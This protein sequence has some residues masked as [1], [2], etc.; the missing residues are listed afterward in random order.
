VLERAVQRAGELPRQ[1]SRPDA[2][3]GPGPVLEHHD[4]LAGDRIRAALTEDGRDPRGLGAHARGQRDG[5]QAR[6]DADEHGTPPGTNVPLDQLTHA[7]SRCLP[8][9]TS[10]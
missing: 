6:D 1:T 4:V 5:D 9:R 3:T 8:D 7:A 2:G 10:P